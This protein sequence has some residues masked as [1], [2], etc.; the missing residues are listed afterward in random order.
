[1]PKFVRFAPSW[2][3]TSSTKESLL[4]PVG[5]A[6]SPRFP[7]WT[8]ISHRPGGAYVSDA[9]PNTKHVTGLHRAE[10]L[11]ADAITHQLKKVTKLK[12]THPI[13]LTLSDSV[14]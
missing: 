4:E 14:C 5:R 8:R 12:E 1:M 11:A 2:N 9:A 10:A 6:S 7:R 3:S 13:E